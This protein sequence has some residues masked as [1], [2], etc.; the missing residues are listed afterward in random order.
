LSADGTLPDELYT[1]ANGS[2]F[3]NLGVPRNPLNPFYLMRLVRDDT[4]EP[5]NPD[6]FQFV[7]L[8]VGGVDFDG[9]GAPDFPDRKAEFKIPTMRNLVSG[10]FPRACF[11]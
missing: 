8:G 4:G 9:D 2:G 10:S 5:I 11:P 3:F 6:G 1:P 7:D